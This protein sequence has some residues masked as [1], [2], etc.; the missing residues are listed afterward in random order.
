ML[1]WLATF[2]NGKFGAF[3]SSRC[4]KLLIRLGAKCRPAKITFAHG[5]RAVG[6][7]G[8]VTITLKPSASGLKALKNALRHK[9]GLPVT[10]SFTFQSSLGGS[11]FSHSQTVTVKLKK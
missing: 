6:A 5:S 8:G 10:V 2:Q 9:K 3:A 11:P 7:A 1:S 4:K